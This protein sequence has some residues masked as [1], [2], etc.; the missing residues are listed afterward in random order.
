LAK[1][2]KEELAPNILAYIAW[3]NRTTNWIISEIVTGLTL[4]RRTK[5]VEKFIDIGDFSLSINNL[6]T[7]MEV[8]SALN[9]GPVY[10][11]KQTWAALSDK[12]KETWEKLK[13][14]VSPDLNYANMRKI[15][16]DWE[17]IETE[18]DRLP[19]LGLFLQDLL[20]Y[21][22]I[23]TRTTEGELIN[24]HKMRK[25]STT[26]KQI[27][28]YQIP[29]TIPVNEPVRDFLISEDI[30]LLEEADQFKHS[31]QCEGKLPE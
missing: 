18:I 30:V 20:A 12:H 14:V 19:Y 22:E 2:N 8:V 3:F 5:L 29:V 4:K 24:F 31:K 27:K 1:K 28:S 23:P 11:L 7:L 26:L 13:E 15:M 25:I 6:N 16:K 10:R 9:Q 21:E 17:K